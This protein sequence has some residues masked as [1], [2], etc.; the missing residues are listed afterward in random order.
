MSG[1]AVTMTVTTAPG[2]PAS[3]DSGIASTSVDKGAAP[4]PALAVHAPSA[5]E[6]SAARLPAPA[7]PSAPSQPPKPQT[8]PHTQPVR[9]LL[10]L[11]RKQIQ[12][13]MAAA[14]VELN[15]L[16]IEGDVLRNAGRV[17]EERILELEQARAGRALQAEGGEG[18]R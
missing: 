16:V 2:I 15:E 13:G 3:Q 14:K 1:K 11:R 5:P 17:I 8:Y 12:D 18:A 10:A 9:D 7:P 6:G 4:A